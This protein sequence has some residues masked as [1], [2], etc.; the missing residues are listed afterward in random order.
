MANRKF[1]IFL[2]KPSHYDHDGYVIQWMRSSIPSN[3]LASVYGLLAE[4]ADDKVL[5]PDVDIE[6]DACDECNTVVNVKRIIARDQDGRRRL[7]RPGRRAVEPVPARDRHRRA[8]FRAAGIPVVI[9]GFHVGGCIS[10]LPELPPDLKEALDLGI[11]LFAGEAEG[12]MATLLR[13][14]DAA[15]L[16]ADLQL[17]ER[18][19]RHGGGHVPDPARARWSS[20]CGQIRELRCRPRLPVPVQLLHH[21]QRAGPQV[22]LPHAR[23]RR[24]DHP[25]QLR[26]R[27]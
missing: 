19:A 24:G 8:Q 7:R 1:K 17:H 26:R 13:D 15:Q 18:P 4:C 20:G 14:I 23:R 12:R 3:S 2:I 10:M 11:T 27:A 21:H 16:E 22:A 9:G 25:R 5:G 6:I